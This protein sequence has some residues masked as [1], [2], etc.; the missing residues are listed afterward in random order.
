MN[1][2]TSGL[3]ANQDS[4]PATPRPPTSSSPDDSSR[5][6]NSEMRLQIAE[7]VRQQIDRERTLFETYV[8]KWI[9]LIGSVLVIAGVLLTVLAVRT[10][11][12]VKTIAVE[13]VMKKTEELITSE[14]SRTGIRHS[15]QDALNR[16][17]VASVL[18]SD[19][20]Q[21][22]PRR[23]SQNQY[24][25]IRLWL[26]DQELD[27]A[28]FADALAVLNEQDEKDK[29]RD[30]LRLLSEMLNPAPDSTYNWILN[31]P[32]KRQAILEIFLHP[33]MAPT[34]LQILLSQDSSATLKKSASE[35]IRRVQFGEANDQLREL[36]AKTDNGPVRESLFVTCAAF[37]PAHDEFLKEIDGLIASTDKTF[38]V[39]TGFEI[40]VQLWGDRRNGLSIADSDREKVTNRLLPF[41]L[42]N[43]GRFM[44]LEAKLGSRVRDFYGNFVTPPREVYRVYYDVKSG[45]H[46]TETSDFGSVETFKMFT[47]YWSYLH[48]IV[49]SNDL[50]KLQQVLPG[51]GSSIYSRGYPIGSMILTVGEECDVTV[52]TVGRPPFCRPSEMLGNRG[53]LIAC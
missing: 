12:D 51:I 19:T 30:A 10:L 34:A 26:A 13:H 49:N 2:E 46:S 7:E 8:G 45:T 29:K 47:P 17:W 15:L 1:D 27:Y 18:V 25:Q 4:A 44:I 28:Q 21:D 22:A 43:G 37:E 38:A 36:L 20:N 53:W 39:R 9:K 35:Y 50:A 42:A 11:Q 32:E 6:L 33:A 3:N 52:R 48:A 5:T 16:A 14:D 40:L 23:L 24:E 31:E 41:V